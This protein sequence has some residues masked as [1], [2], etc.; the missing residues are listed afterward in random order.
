M[1]LGVAAQMFTIGK[2]Y[3]TKQIMRQM[4]RLP[5]DAELQRS[6]VASKKLLRVGLLV[7]HTEI[8]PSILLPNHWATWAG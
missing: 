2:W 7:A 4:F 1:G 5:G 6:F 3:S 8:F